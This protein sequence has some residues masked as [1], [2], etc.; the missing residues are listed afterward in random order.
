MQWV[1]N[2]NDYIISKKKNKDLIQL[3]ILN[4]VF[5]VY[6]LYV[7]EKKP[8]EESVIAINK[9]S[10]LIEAILVT[11]MPDLFVAGGYY[12][13]GINDESAR[14]ILDT[15]KEESDTY[16]NY[17]IYLENAVRSVFPHGDF[18]TECIH[19][20]NQSNEAKQIKGDSLIDST[21][22]E[23]LTREL[24]ESLEVD[25]IL[26]EKVT[27]NDI[28]PISKFYCVVVNNKL[29]AIGEHELENSVSCGISQVYTLEE[30]RG[31]GY[32]RSIIRHIA[33]I[34]KG[35]NKMPVYHF[36]MANIASKKACEHAS[37]MDCIK[38]GYVEI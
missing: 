36:S 14:A 8:E 11:G 38:L 21:I 7:C 37:F 24:Y 22:V 27:P 1:K 29:I 31:K 13:T 6:S 9:E 12:L 18:S 10:Q 20:Y 30:Y 4:P 17:P 34:I 35:N 19:V 26:Y 25:D 2:M 23:H 5:Q 28:D 32:A 3:L 15:I 33:E 16:V